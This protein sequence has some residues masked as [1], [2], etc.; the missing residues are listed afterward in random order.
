[1]ET[2]SPSRSGLYNEAIMCITVWYCTGSCR[3]S[4][5]D[6]SCQHKLLLLLLDAILTNMG[7]GRFPLSHLCAVVVGEDGKK[8]KKRI[9]QI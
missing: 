1:M 9:H 4:H 2:L 8:K 3:L 5:Y 7:N 6:F